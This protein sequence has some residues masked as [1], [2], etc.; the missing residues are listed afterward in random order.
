MNKNKTA[1]NPFEAQPAADNEQRLSTVNDRSGLPSYPSA[2]A[3]SD[4]SGSAAE[5]SEIRTGQAGGD[6]SVARRP[7]NL[8]VAVV[9]LG[10]WLLLGVG[11]LLFLWFLVTGASSAGEGVE[12]DKEVASSSPAVPSV[13]EADAIVVLYQTRDLQE[14]FAVLNDG[15]FTTVDGET[16]FDAYWFEWD[17]AR[18]SEAYV[19]SAPVSGGYLT[20]VPFDDG[21]LWERREAGDALGERHFRFIPEVGSDL[22]ED[23]WVVVDC[24]RAAPTGGV[25]GR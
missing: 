13:S 22:I 11:V 1:P 23:Y 21:F 20:V 8:T 15:A 17:D 4:A 3:N 12:T 25:V 18:A 6:S 7:V 14:H 19:C 5:A 16:Q 24:L 10:V 2:A 9:G